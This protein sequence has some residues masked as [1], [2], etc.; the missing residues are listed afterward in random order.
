[1]DGD[2]FLQAVAAPAPRLA[3]AVG[4]Y[5]QGNQVRALGERWTGSAWSAVPAASPGAFYNS[6]QAIAATSKTNAWAVGAKNP[7]QG[8]AFRTLAE[9]WNGTS[10]AAVTSPS[11]GSNDDW[12]FGLT[13]LPHGGGFWAVGTAGDRTLIER[14]C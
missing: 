14:H 3:L 7:A 2:R 13:A 10:W 4:S 6:L 12:L 5:L 1:G 11:P 8:S 9:H